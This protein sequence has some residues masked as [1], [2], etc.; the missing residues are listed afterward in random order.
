M[1]TAAE[2][3]QLKALA[4]ALGEG[5]KESPVD[6]GGGL[7]V[8]RVALSS[9]SVD[10]WTR[11]SL[12]GKAYRVH[13]SKRA[14]AAGAH[15]EVKEPELASFAPGDALEGARTEL[16]LR[17]RPDSNTVGTCVFQC[18]RRPGVKLEEGDFAGGPV[19][20]TALL[21]AVGEE[22]GA[23]TYVSV[24]EDTAPSGAPASQAGAFNCSGW[25]KIRV[26]ING[27]A[28]ETTD[29]VPW[30]YRGGTADGTGTTGAWTENGL[31]RISVP[32]ST[33][34]AYATR[35]FIL[36]VAGNGWMFFQPRSL[37]PAGLTALN[38]LVEGIE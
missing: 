34:T 19:K 29:L 20:P 35:S 9:L 1:T 33:P 11:V 4:R 14:S 38:M 37:L 10:R 6:D 18:S 31:E 15:L 23:I 7:S 30:Q 25:R 21:G 13:F 12:G 8:K 32:D 24:A 22:S 2:V 16:E 3:L 17:L 36:N 26:T 27:T 5:L 28:L